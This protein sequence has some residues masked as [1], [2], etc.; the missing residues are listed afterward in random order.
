MLPHTPKHT[1]IHTYT[2][3]HTHTY[4]YASIKSV[5]FTDLE[6]IVKSNEERKAD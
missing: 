2:H 5:S 1:H 6:V 3:T 4:Q